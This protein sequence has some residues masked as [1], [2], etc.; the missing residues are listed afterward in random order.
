M[1][2]SGVDWHNQVPEVPW[3]QRRERAVT[4][5]RLQRALSMAKRAV[6]AEN[7]EAYGQWMT[8]AEEYA[9]QLRNNT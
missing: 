6:A 1:T 5:A 8:L 3:P 2:D 7:W 9:G 4:K